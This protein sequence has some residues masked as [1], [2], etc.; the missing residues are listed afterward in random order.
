MGAPPGFRGGRPDHPPV[1][2]AAKIDNAMR[3]VALDTFAERIGLKRGQ[4]RRKPGAMVLA[5]RDCRR[6]RPPTRPFWR[7]LP[8]GATAIAARGHST[9]H[10]MGLFLGHHRLRPSS[11]R[12]KKALVS[13]SCGVFLSRLEARATV[14]LP[15]PGL[16]WGCRPLR[17]WRRH[18]A[19]DGTRCLHLAGRRAATAGGHPRPHSKGRAET[20]RRSSRS[21]PGRARPPLRSSFSSDSIKARGSRT[22]RAFGPA[23]RAELLAGA[24]ARRAGA[25]RGIHS[26]TDRH[27]ARDVRSSLERHGE[28]GRLFEAPPV[29]RRRPVFRVRAMRRALERCRRIAALF[30]SGCRRFHGHL[31]A[32]YGFRNRPG[33]RSSKRKLDPAQQDFSRRPDESQPLA[34]FVAQVSARFGPG[35]LMQATLAESHLRN[36]RADLPP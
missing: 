1:V 23:A 19:R 10:G 8:T 28:G 3:L 2:F 29:P 9:G 33:F 34:A 12:Q 31:D 11:R 17:R 27:L 24:P 4:G 18:C 35:C 5:R 22:S 21:G 6:I 36:G 7:R 15:Q 13:M 16:S 32:G 30:Q 20:D 26:R 25:G 14:S